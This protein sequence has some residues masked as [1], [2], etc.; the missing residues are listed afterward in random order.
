MGTPRRLSPPPESVRCPECP[1]RA[2]CSEVALHVYG[3]EDAECERCKGTG[4][5]LK[6]KEL[7]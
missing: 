5:V 4:F 3:I 2:G 6:P 1:T 7:S